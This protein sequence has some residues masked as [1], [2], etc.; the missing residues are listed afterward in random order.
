MSKLQLKINITII[1][2]ITSSIFLSSCVDNPVRKKL[3]DSNSSYY[4]GVHAFAAKLDGNKRAE[5]FYKNP[6]N[7][8]KKYE[9]LKERAI[10]KSEQDR[11]RY[12]EAQKRKKL[13]AA[14]QNSSGGVDFGSFLLGGYVALSALGRG[15]VSVAEYANKNNTSTPAERKANNNIYQCEK[16][17]KNKY[18]KAIKQCSGLSRGSAGDVARAAIFLQKDPPFQQC[19][20][21]KKK[22]K[23]KCLSSCR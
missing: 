12:I 22:W 14:R 15:A 17:C 4:Q 9:Y 5:A 16:D 21:P 3:A 23:N 19:E 10:V 8:G 2:V 20:S 6:K 7:K 13:A 11:K 1:G 18:N